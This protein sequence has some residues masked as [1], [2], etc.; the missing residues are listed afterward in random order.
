MP[1][2]TMRQILDHA[3]ENNY[4]VPAFNI[5]DMEQVIA[6][7]QAAR[8]VNAPVILATARLSKGLSCTAA[9]AESVS[10]EDD[11]PSIYVSDG[12]LHVGQASSASDV[13]ILTLSGICIKSVSAGS[14][15]D[16]PLEP[17][18]YIVDVRQTDGN[19]LLTKKIVVR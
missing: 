19:C 8:K 13:R 11:V 5:N 17:G 3:A 18:I 4:G 1:L 2:V 7:L 15:I 9:G 12:L 14:A 16:I 10:A 6:V